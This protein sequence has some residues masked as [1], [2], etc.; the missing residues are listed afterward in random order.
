MSIYNKNGTLKPLLKSRVKREMEACCGNWLRWENFW[1]TDR[2]EFSDPERGMLAQVSTE[3]FPTNA[4]ILRTLIEEVSGKNTVVWNGLPK[5]PFTYH[6]VFNYDYVSLMLFVKDKRGVPTKEFLTFLY[7]EIMRENYPI[8]DD[9][10][11]AVYR[12]MRIRSDL[13]SEVYQLIASKKQVWKAAPEKIT[14]DLCDQWEAALSMDGSSDDYLDIPSAPSRRLLTLWLRDRPKE[15]FPWQQS[16]QVIRWAKYI[17]RL[18]AKLVA[19][20]KLATLSTSL[21][22]LPNAVLQTLSQYK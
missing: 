11:Y 5:K 16:K 6:E 21:Q 15:A 20:P 2:S 14:D 18:Q 1:R 19:L 13:V 4:L 22:S 7:T 17:K 12:D 8:L 3:A 9:D 10:L